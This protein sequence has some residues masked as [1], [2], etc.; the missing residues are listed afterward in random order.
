[1][2]QPTVSGTSTEDDLRDALHRCSEDTIAAALRFQDERDPALAEPIVF[3]VIER[4]LDPEEKAVLAR[5]DPQTRLMEDLRIDSLLMVE[6]VMIVEQ[7]LDIR[8]QNDEFAGISTVGDLQAFITR[9]VRG[10]A[11]AE[12]DAG[13]TN[14]RFAR[15]RIL[16]TLPMAPPFLFLDEASVTDVGARGEYR[17]SGEESFFQGH[18]PG[19]PIAPAS[20]LIE[21]AGQLAALHVLGNGNP[22]PAESLRFV[23]CDGVRCLRECR[24]GEKLDLE[25]ELVR[26]RQ[27]LYQFSARISVGG[28]TAVR[29][30][31]LNLAV[32]AVE[33]TSD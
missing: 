22:G 4:F 10:D 1:M 11:A 14:G 30:A 28:E 26:T 18:F 25:V 7:V 9:K 19:D 3:G 31:S 2:T 6:I 8:V 27:P 23:S 13:R 29:V 20:I 21:S 16:A 17:L 24:P 12:E 33:G 15:E 5:R 32:G